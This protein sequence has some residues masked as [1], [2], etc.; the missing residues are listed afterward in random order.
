[1]K[2][3]Q[4]SL[5][6]RRGPASRVLLVALGLA[7]ALQT[8]NTQSWAASLEVK[9]NVVIKFD[10]NADLV[11]RDS[12]KAGKNVTLTSQKEETTE[13][14]AAG[15]WRG[16]RL[17]KSMTGANA[18][19]L[20]GWTLR[21][22]DT[23]LNIRAQNP[24]LQNLQLTDNLL[25]LRLT[26]AAS[27][28]I[29]AASF[30]NNGIGVQA[31]GNSNPLLHNTQLTG[32]SQW[33]MTNLSP[34]TVI[35]AR[36]N[37]WGHASGP[38][39]IVANPQGQGDAVSAGVDY[40]AFLSGA[41]LLNPEIRLVSTETNGGKWGGALIPDPAAS[42]PNSSW[43]S[44]P[45]DGA[46]NA[47]DFTVEA[48]VNVDADTPL[49]HRQ[50]IVAM[51]SGNF[52]G[53]GAWN[54]AISNI[55]QVFFQ[56]DTGSF[57]AY[58]TTDVR[59][60]GWTHIAVTRASSV[61]TIWVNGVAEAT[62]TNGLNLDNSY[63]LYVGGWAVGDA[64]AIK[65]KIDEVR[66]S[67]GAR[68][69]DTFTPPSEP[70]TFSTTEAGFQDLSVLHFDGSLIDEN[71][72]R[73]WTSGG[74]GDWASHPVTVSGAY[75]QATVQLEVSCQNATEYRLA[76]GDNFTGDFLP[77]SNGRVQTSF[78]LSTGDGRKP[79]SVQFRNAS[80]A[81]VTA[82]LTG[83]VLVDTE[84]PTLTW[85]SPAAGS[86]ITQ[87]TPLEVNATDGSGIR[88]VQF[89]L[90]DALLATRTS[91]PYRTTWTPTADVEE[92]AHTLKA[93]ATDEAGHSSEQ[94]VQVTVT[95]GVTCPAV[96]APQIEQPANGLTTQS[97]MLTVTGTAEVGTNVRVWRNG[98]A[99][100]ST[101]QAGSDGRFSAPLQLVAGVN[102]IQ[103]VATNACG[104]SPL[105]VAVSVTLEVPLPVS[106]TSLSAVSQAG[107]KVK[108]GWTRS[109]DTG[110]TKQELYRAAGDFTSVGEAERIA[111]LAANANSYEDLPPAD[112]TW[113]YRIVS[114]N[115]ANV[116]SA[117]SN[118]ATVT[119]DATL[120]K[121][122]S[123]TYT[124]RG[125]VDTVNGR[126]GQGWVDLTLTLS[127]ALQGQ[128]YFALVPHGGA[129]IPVELTRVDATRY[130]GSLLID[131]NT[132]SGSA[133]SLF[134]ARDL[135][136]NR[137]TEIESGATFEIDTAGPVLADIQ[138]DPS[139][140]VK[141]DSAQTLNVTFT[142]NKA[143][144]TVPQIKYQLSG[145]SRS[146]V[147]LGGLSKL[148]DLSYKAVFTLPA[149]AG[150][151]QPEILSFS[152]QAQDDLDNVSIKV[153]ASNR[154]QVYQGELP[155][156]ETPFAFT[157]TALPGGKV[158]L[159]WQAVDEAESYQLYRQTP[160]QSELQALARTGGVAYIDQTPADGHYK[161]SVASVRQANEQESISAQSVVREIEARASAPG[162][163]Q[164]LTLTLTGQGI[165]ASWLPPLASEVDYYNLY[166]ATG[167]TIAD[168]AGLSPLKTRIGSAQALDPNPDANQSVYVVTA[169]DKVGNESV[170]SNSAYLNASLLPVRNL[171]IEHIGDAQP[172]LKWDAPN[173]QI[174]GYLVYVGSEASQI[175]LT[176]EPIGARQIT[177][178]GYTGGERRYTIASVDAQ[179]EKMPRSILLPDIASQLVSGLPIRR[180]LMNKLQVQVA[181]LSNATQDNVRVVIRLPV[182]AQNKEH[183]SG[184][185]TLAPNETR[186]VTVIVGGYA[187]LTH[188]VA[189]Q[190]GVD[191]E[192]EGE[193]IKIAHNQSLDVV[194]DT[195]LVSLT[196]ADFTRGATG[197]V[198]IN[199]E[200]TSEVDVELLA[201]TNN[202]ANPSSELRFKLLDEEDNILAVQAWKQVFGAD[203]VTLTNGQTVAR[204]PA[205]QTFVSNPFA[206]NVPAAS[207]DALRVRLEMDSLRYHSGQEDEV[208]IGGRS[209]ERRVNLSDVPY[210]GEITD[211][212]PANSFGDEDITIRGRA[213][214]RADGSPLANT[215]LKLVL[216][217]QGY[218][219][220]YTVTT[221][222]AG[223]FEYVFH[224]TLTDAGLIK[225]SAVHPDIT[226]RPEQR[227]FTI[228]RVTVTPSPY[229]LSVPR[230]YA[231]N[232]PFV[233]KAGVG[234]AAT[235]LR[236]VLDAASQPTGQIPA[237][238]ALT[239]PAPVTLAERQSKSLAVGFVANNDAQPSG[240]L[241]LDLTSDE[242]PEPLGKVRIDYTLSEAKP[243]L[244]SAPSF[245]ETGL[246]QGGSQIETV[247]IKNNGLQDALDLQFTLTKANGAPAPAWANIGNTVNGTLE[248]GQTRTINL[249]FAP[250][251]NTQEGV[252]E[253]RLT[254]TGENVPEQSLNV[255]VSLSQSGQGG[256]LFKVS[257]IYTATVGKDGKVIQGL[258]NARITLQNE[259]V[260]TLSYEQRSD[261]LGETLFQNIP[262]GRYTFKA[263]A[264]NHQEIGGRLT[265]KPGITQ[266]Q[267]VFLDY[268]LITV[269]WRVKEI[270]IEDRYEITLNATF[271][272]D[273]PA[274]VVVLEPHSINLP[275]MAVGEVFYGEL[276]ATNYGLIR[277]EH[278]SLEPPP[279]DAY[280]RYE[281]L[282]EIPGTL[283]PKQRVVIPYRVI[284]VKALWDDANDGNA[285][286]GGCSAY[287]ATCLLHYDFICSNGYRSKYSV[288]TGFVAGDS[289]T[290]PSGGSGSGAGG[291]AWSGGAGGYGGGGGSSINAPGIRC[292]STP[293]GKTCGN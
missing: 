62:V 151:A 222:G 80:G 6:A 69:T 99:Y 184:P 189:A 204:I 185:I 15:D 188:T 263:S 26:D 121:V 73:T 172:E 257:D 16:L 250:P 260:P 288:P 269:E 289:S 101:V 23:A 225:V 91:A 203:V 27:P 133:N 234:T 236:L 153:A 293:N 65:G 233:G 290:C 57:H 126:Y 60:A 45:L 42:Y 252:Y 286:G 223:A 165:Y 244:V 174:S 183:K 178:T 168:I 39:D 7:V 249:N 145:Q 115:A 129:P 265:V 157:A 111:A 54:L 118:A 198:K 196:P 285:S 283:E 22:A 171:R 124:A 43:I 212:S 199:V 193:S 292:V 117:P 239:L 270:T 272:T 25:G 241:I 217:Q 108:L 114:I 109:A 254:V 162:A 120:P 46:W 176:P 11:V 128:P 33:A 164:N 40:G 2:D 32:N 209:A 71:P 95:R 67:L 158:K 143:P 55:G 4:Q 63:N 107:G 139:A 59:G 20:E 135:L 179:G 262:A 186:L 197:Q 271:E 245:V 231:F 281:L 66:I 100:G 182:G 138:L 116:L 3:T 187:E 74:A 21:Y 192:R 280:F 35:N 228:N 14:S 112:G 76:E 18:L 149:D 267:A 113:T 17:E 8:S 97:A 170:P 142:Y 106:P 258:S 61:Y 220:S 13:P 181:N 58:G 41:P 275:R 208:K 279:N 210:I 237:G 161:Y 219:R 85:V 282:A 28:N 131:A 84:A 136:G 261:A 1:M 180:G 229:K 72:N 89:Y 155:P 70:F 247:S 232:I 137:G 77:L 81:I 173:G 75:E 246:Q 49:V 50:S 191:I 218:E 122:E 78:T 88:Q 123:V 83:G 243:Y 90:D 190:I 79:I 119:S 44:S 48:W 177:D 226:D 166:R 273:V 125:K 93:V 224:P 141:N 30:L 287:R 47:N 94:S 256:I 221:D 238:V 206:V 255:Y 277:A 130:T 216:N 205:G 276:V 159:T 37:W 105:S 291:W 31:E 195:L 274:A 34:E 194:D 86:V 215:R 147:I 154:Y 110:I 103:A 213:L 36:N 268:N 235:N 211:I 56:N 227:N 156:L 152:Q 51:S 202:G 134:S 251:A 167:T 284:A 24:S 201:A 248:V 87:A 240:A 278:V 52:W 264:A 29:S 64:H 207:P 19:V 214:N 12:L 148:N 169:V 230:N 175:Q 253:F 150:A 242:H 98:Q 144:A 92:G 5:F 163:P 9:D 160:E 104:S 68:Y 53:G 140:P 10:T 200:N 102:Q 266:N 38:K 146:P 82:Q 127:E 96:A 259:E 132:P